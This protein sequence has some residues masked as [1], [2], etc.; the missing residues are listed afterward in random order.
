MKRSQTA[1]T[2]KE[3]IVE[4]INEED[5]Q[6]FTKIVI[7]LLKDKDFKKKVAKRQSECKSWFKIL[8]KND[9]LKTLGVDPC[10]NFK[11]KKVKNSNEWDVDITV[12]R[13][14]SSAL[15]EFF[16]LSSSKA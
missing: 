15:E 13:L 8:C 2:S 9:D 10:F 11:F 5:R 3:D 6:K 14:P 7:D 12:K 16:N 4:F 1:K